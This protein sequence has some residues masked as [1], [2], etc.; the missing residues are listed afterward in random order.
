MRDFILT[1]AAVTRHP[2][3]AGPV[4]RSRCPS[5]WESESSPICKPLVG[6]AC[7]FGEGLHFA[8]RTLG[9]GL[10]GRSGA[11]RS[12]ARRP[13]SAVTL[14]GAGASESRQDAV[15]I[16]AEALGPPPGA[17]SCPLQSALARRRTTA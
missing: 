17:S 13:G 3:L 10:G 2:E 8:R 7:P 4:G 14:R 6:E 11:S 5:P 12:P 1:S 9:G 16:R 15:H